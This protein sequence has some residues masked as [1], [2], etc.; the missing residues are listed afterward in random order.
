ML[1]FTDTSNTERK[2]NR[3]GQLRSYISSPGRGEHRG[4]GLGDGGNVQSQSSLIPASGFKGCVGGTE[5][6]RPTEGRDWPPGTAE[7]TYQFSPLPVNFK[8]QV[9]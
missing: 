2:G 8:P 3:P 9:L 1:R 4:R 6:E 5:K 7:V